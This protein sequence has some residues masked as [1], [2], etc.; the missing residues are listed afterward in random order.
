VPSPK[1]S[2]PIRDALR[3]AVKEARGS[4]RI[5]TAVEVDVLLADR[6]AGIADVADEDEFVRVAPQLRAALDRLPL[7][8]VEA[9]VGSG[10]DDPRGR[11][12]HALDSPPALGHSANA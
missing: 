6:L 12:L 3:E 11:V 8:R 9:P 2:T 5:T 4:G 7:E 1:Q 10:D